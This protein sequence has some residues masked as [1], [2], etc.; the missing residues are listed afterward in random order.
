MKVNRGLG[1][2]ILFHG[3]LSVG[4]N[5]K[6]ISYLLDHIFTEITLP[7]IIAGKNPPEW[8]IKKTAHIPHVTLVGNPDAEVMNHLIQNAQ[9]NLIPTFQSTGLKLK[10]L[11][12]LFHGRHCITNSPMTRN[13]GL[14]H[15]CYLADNVKDMVEIIQKK[16]EE[17][18]TVEEINQRKELLENQFSNANN[19]QKIYEII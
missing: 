4:E 10:L 5:Q 11:A 6:A 14:S 1:E 9:I 12:S 7:L 3:N 13:T 16:F 15:L 17:K 19:A 2:Y 18:I 8:L